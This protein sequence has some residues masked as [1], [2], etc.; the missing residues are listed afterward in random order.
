[1]QFEDGFR[2]AGPPNATELPPQINV[3]VAYNV[4]S[5]NAF[6]KYMPFDFEMDKSPITLRVTGATVLENKL[7]RLRIVPTTPGFEIEVLGFGLTRD[8]LIDA[9]VGE[10]SDATEV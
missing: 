4:R 3:H 1:M 8:I 6:K 5:G 2:I 9:K 10:R 7:N